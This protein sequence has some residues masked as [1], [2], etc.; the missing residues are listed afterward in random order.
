[1]KCTQCSYCSNTFDPF[2]DLSLQ[3]V[4][5][6]SLPKALAHFTAVEELDGG[7]KQYQ[8]ARCKEKVRARKQLTI[9]KAPYV[10]TIHLKRFGSGEP[11]HKIDK[12]VEFGTT[13]NLKPY[14][15]G[16]YVS[17]LRRVSLRQTSEGLLYLIIL[18]FYLFIKEGDLKYSLYGVLVHAGWSTHS[19]H[20]FCFV[21]TSSG[22][23]HA[24]DDNRVCS[25]PRL[26]LH[27]VAESNQECLVQLIGLT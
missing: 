10:L 23:W 13:L 1:M 21:R 14:V 3:I 19:G 15:S 25:H 4:K 22:I 16:P 20:Y 9:H 6:D 26:L 5:S 27:L 2:L 12:K 17:V 8:C 11:G 24:L 7:Q 18:H